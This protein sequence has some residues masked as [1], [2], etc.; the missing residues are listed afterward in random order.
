MLTWLLAWW[1]IGAA[2]IALLGLIAVLAIGWEMVTDT[3]AWARQAFHGK[4]S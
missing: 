2:F 3:I 4:R 1:M